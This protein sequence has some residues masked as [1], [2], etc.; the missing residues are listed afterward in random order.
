MQAVGVFALSQPLVGGSIP[1]IRARHQYAEEYM[2]FFGGVHPNEIRRNPTIARRL[3]TVR[4]RYARPVSPA[5]RAYTGAETPGFGRGRTDRCAIAQS[6]SERHVE[7]ESFLGA[8]TEAD[9][10][11]GYGN[12]RGGGSPYMD[13][14]P[15]SGPNSQSLELGCRGIASRTHIFCSLP[16]IT[17]TRRNYLKSAISPILAATHRCAHAIRTAQTVAWCSTSKNNKA[18]YI[19]LMARCPSSPR[20]APP[21][22]FGCRVS[23]AS[24]SP[25]GE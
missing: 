13:S 23:E 1:L 4:C 20:D 12:L 5:E 10:V 17:Q 9:F 7:P 11:G 3:V 18:T 8:Q 19:A 24:H 6:T 2:G 15:T 25:P 22:P 21:T 16:S 14:G